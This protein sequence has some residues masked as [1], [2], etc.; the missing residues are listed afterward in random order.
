MPRPS[1]ALYKI[2]R[3]FRTAEAIA[4]GHPQRIARTA[5]NIALG[6]ALEKAGVWR[7]LWVSYS[8]S[9]VTCSHRVALGQRPLLRPLTLR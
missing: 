9:V 1:S 5:K 4:S 3:G 2:A 8:S 7:R 6:R